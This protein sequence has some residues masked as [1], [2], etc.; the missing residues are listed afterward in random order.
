MDGCPKPILNRF[1]KQIEGDC[2][3]KIK[4]AW[5]NLITDATEPEDWLTTDVTT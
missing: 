4:R 1:I 2:Q 5:E 3:D